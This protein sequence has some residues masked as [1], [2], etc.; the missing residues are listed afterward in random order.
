MLNVH[1]NRTRGL[2][3][4]PRENSKTGRDEERL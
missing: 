4:G 1:G 2:R 3:M